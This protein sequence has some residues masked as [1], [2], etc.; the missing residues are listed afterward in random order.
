M[1]K[2]GEIALYLDKQG[3]LKPLDGESADR[4]LKLFRNEPYIFSMKRARNYA[5]LK[6]YFS[7]INL[8][9]DNQEK[10]DN[11]EWFRKWSLIAV[12]W[13]KEYINPFD[14]KV[15]YEVKSVSFEKCKESEFDEV[16]KNTVQL[17]IDRF[18][19]DEDFFNRLNN[20]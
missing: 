20:Y 15:N 12:G 18:C 7:L 13:C 2:K 14:G 5:F 9:F 4:Y 6:K 19:F 1:L 11:I 17:F 16:Y 3:Q 10:F 8:A